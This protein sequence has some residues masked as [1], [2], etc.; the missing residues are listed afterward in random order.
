MGEEYSIILSKNITLELVLQVVFPS[1]QTL[2]Y[3]LQ[4]KSGCKITF[5]VHSYVLALFTSYVY[6]LYCADCAAKNDHNDHSVS[7][8]NRFICIAKRPLLPDTPCLP[9]SMIRYLA[10]RVHFS[11]GWLPLMRSTS[12]PLRADMPSSNRFDIAPD[13]GIQAGKLLFQAGFAH[14]QK[15]LAQTGFD[16]VRRY[17]PDLSAHGLHKGTASRSRRQSR[18]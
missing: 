10:N 3:V 7:S 1:F 9:N 18:V 4:N 6:V 13:S 15:P 17:R 5:Y 14:A 11:N 16:V 8:V 12:G 2:L